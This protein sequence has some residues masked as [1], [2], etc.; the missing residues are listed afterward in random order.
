M[1]LG[2]LPRRNYTVEYMGLGADGRMVWHK[3]MTTTSQYKAD[4]KAA[5]I[6]KRGRR[7]RVMVNPKS[8]TVLV[9]VPRSKVVI[10]PG[11]VVKI[12]VPGKRRAKTNPKKRCATHRKPR[13]RTNRRRVNRAKPR[14]AATKK[15][16]A[17]RR[18]TRR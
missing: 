18:R 14:R 6:A 17:N 10:G 16:A 1:S 3:T 2:P 11:G 15:R 8:K 7:V 12:R 5:A 13:A 9:R 4:R